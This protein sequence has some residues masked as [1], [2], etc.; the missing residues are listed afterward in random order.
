LID[1][2]DK[3]LFSH[4]FSLLFDLPIFNVSMYFLRKVVRRQRQHHLNRVLPLAFKSSSSSYLPQI[5]PT[6]G[7][8]IHLFADEIEPQAM[9]QVILLAESPIPVDYVSVMPD[10]HLG[11]GV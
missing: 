7:V 2:S 11:K 8:P 3:Q 6:K 1:A 4:L 5:I 10:A 9:A